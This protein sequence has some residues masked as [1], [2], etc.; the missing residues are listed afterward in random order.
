MLYDAVHGYGQSGHDENSA[1]EPGLNFARMIAIAHIDEYG[2][3]DEHDKRVNN[4]TNN[5][6]HF[7]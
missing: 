7:F 6:D 1:D 3:Y 5:G 2:K 4:A